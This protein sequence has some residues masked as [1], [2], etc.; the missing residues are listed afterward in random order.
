MSDASTS[1]D[2]ELISEELHYEAYAFDVFSTQWRAPDGRSFQRDLVRHMGAVAIVPVT[3]DGHLLMVR[4]FRPA[5]GRWLLEL[6][7]GLR[8]VEGEADVDVARRELEEEVGHVAGAIEHLITLD[9]AV[10]GKHRGTGSDQLLI[11]DS[12][13]D[14]FRLGFKRC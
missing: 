13:P 11:S 5:L 3:A 9:T 4:Q 8:D 6:P 7:A 2:F 1:G 10:G 12:S 14:G